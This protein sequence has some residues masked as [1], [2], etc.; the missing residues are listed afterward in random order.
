MPMGQMPV[1]EVDGKRVYQ[2]LAISRYIA[3]QVGLAGADDWES[4]LI[5][6]AVDNVNDFRVKMA[7]P[8][9]EKDE[10]AKAKKS[11]T[12]KTEVLPFFLDKLEA[13]AAENSGHLALGKVKHCHIHNK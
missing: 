5:D 12:V 2:S 1:L 8:L 6:I 7:A 13:I 3:K 11:E 10:D 9:Y 4:L